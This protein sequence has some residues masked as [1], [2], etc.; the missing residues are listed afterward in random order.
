M[1][2]RA[3]LEQLRRW[4][5]AAVWAPIAWFP[6]AIYALMTGRSAWS[7]GIGL[8]GLIFAGVARAVVWSARCPACAVP[9]RGSPGAFRRF[10]DDASCDACGLSLFELRRGRAQD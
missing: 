7:I 9:F 4:R 6:L 1:G 3:T 2:E 8:S 5:Q 10:W